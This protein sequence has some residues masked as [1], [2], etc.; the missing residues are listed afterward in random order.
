L[1]KDGNVDIKV[2]NIRGELVKTILS[3]NMSKGKHIVRWNGKNYNNKSV[4]SG[5][6]FFK[7]QTDGYKK[8]SKALLLK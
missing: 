1:V 4:A 7:M 6:Y 2:Y 5:V 3:E 8:V